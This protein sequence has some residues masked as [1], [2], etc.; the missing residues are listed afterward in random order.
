MADPSSQ[1]QRIHWSKTRHRGPTT[2]RLGREASLG[3]RPL[4]RGGIVGSAKASAAL[5]L[6]DGDRCRCRSLH[7]G[8]RGRRRARGGDDRRV[9]RR[10]RSSGRHRG[11][12]SCSCGTGRRTRRSVGRA[13]CHESGEDSSG[14]DSSDAGRTPRPTR[15]VG[16]APPSGPAGGR[17]GGFVDRALVFGVHRRVPVGSFPRSVEVMSLIIDELPGRFLR[18]GSVV[19]L[20]SRRRLRRHWRRCG[21]PAPGAPAA[22]TAAGDAGLCPVARR[23]RW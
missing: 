1:T 6:R 5:R 22:A 9:R 19:A 23:S 16:T 11:A 8:D 12:G 2:S 20:I 18:T 14:G 4:C 3:V 7:G 15:W 17:D 10:C 21:L 13:D